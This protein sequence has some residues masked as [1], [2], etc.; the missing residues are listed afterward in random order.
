[1]N[2]IPN[3]GIPLRILVNE[4]RR[5]DPE[6]LICQQKAHSDDAENPER[7]GFVPNNIPFERL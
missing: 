5:L 7:F 1:M 4:P 3:L 2:N 6:Q